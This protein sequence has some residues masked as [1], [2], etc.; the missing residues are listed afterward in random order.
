MSMTTTYTLT[1][2]P[3]GSAGWTA[4]EMALQVPRVL[5]WTVGMALLAPLFPVIGLMHLLS[6]EER[7][8]NAR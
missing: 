8:R 7:R 3:S 6:W 2:A 4:G 5:G 1:S